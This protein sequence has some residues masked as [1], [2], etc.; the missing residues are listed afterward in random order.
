MPT[1]RPDLDPIV[2][3]CPVCHRTIWAN[4][5]CPHGTVPPPSKDAPREKD[6][7]PPPGYRP[8]GRDKRRGGLQGP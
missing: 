6:V 2:I 7:P 3:N 4:T 5:V 1:P 8:K